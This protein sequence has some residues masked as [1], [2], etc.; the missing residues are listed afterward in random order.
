M[1]KQE[2]GHD[3]SVFSFQRYF[4]EKNN[5]LHGLSEHVIY[6]VSP[7]LRKEDFVKAEA[8]FRTRDI[9]D[10]WPGLLG[11]V[12][13]CNRAVKQ[14]EW[15]PEDKKYFY[16]LKDAVMEKLYRDPPSGTT[17]SLKKVP[18]EKN[19]SNCADA[20]AGLT[21]YVYSPELSDLAGGCGRPS[22][23][24]CVQETVLIEM[25]VTF[26]GRMYCFHIP[27]EKAKD[28]ELDLMSLSARKWVPSREFN[29]QFFKDYFE[30]IRT[31]LDLVS[32][33]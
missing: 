25:E 12:D 30:E 2:H 28:W 18:Y 6:K 1:L 24:T 14:G 27:H 13:Y 4:K 9:N 33:L 16:N 29:R 22:A 26:A 17:V 15:Y 31:L 21:Q 10:I 32:G 20:P 23:N 11:L 19:Y 7:V 3:V 8:P 5:D